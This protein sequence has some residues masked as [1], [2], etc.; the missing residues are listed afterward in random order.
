MTTQ[1]WDPVG[2]ERHAG[3]V[4]ELG[5]PVVEL[6]AVRPGERVLD[7]GCGDGVLT[8]ELVALGA[9]VVGVDG[10]EAMVA[11]ARS[12]EIDARVMDGHALAFDGEF[13][14]VFSS[15]ALHWMTRPDAVIAGVARALRPG[16]RFVGEMGGHGCVAAITVALVAVLARHDVDG[17]A[18]RPWYFPTPAEYRARLE[19]A[20]LTVTS[21]ELIPRPTRLPGDIRGWLET[22]AQ[23]FLAAVPEL[24]RAALLDEVATL[25]APALCDSQGQW[26]ADYTRLRFAA[27][28]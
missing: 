19:Q 21:I 7:L 24:D 12:R 13:D 1:A 27:L 16:G 28:S 4:P 26:T 2:Y 11:A 18:H 25:L 6:L 17:Y 15:A 3:F 5:K 9:T 8:A 10:S 14:A 20:G 22:F 23:P